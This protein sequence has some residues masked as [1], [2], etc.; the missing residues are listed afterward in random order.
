MVE[1]GGDRWEIAFG[2]DATFRWS[3]QRAL[4]AER[5]SDRMCGWRFQRW[6]RGG[7]VKRVLETLARDREVLSPRQAG[8]VCVIRRR[9]LGGRH[10]WEEHGEQPG[11]MRGRLA[12]RW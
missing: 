11:W 6:V 5:S 12:W 8:P 2:D 4:L 3:R 10:K 1:V 7:M 9:H